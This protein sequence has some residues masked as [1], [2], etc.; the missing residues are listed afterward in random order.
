[1]ESTNVQLAHQHV[2]AIPVPS[3]TA[4][5]SR[6]DD[7]SPSSDSN[8]E[9]EPLY[10]DHEG[11]QSIIQPA[12]SRAATRLTSPAT[13]A[14][15]KKAALDYTSIS[16][17]DDDGIHA[18]REDHP[19]HTPEFQ[20]ST[21]HAQSQ[22]QSPIL[23][24]EH[25][26]Q[27]AIS[28]R[29]PSLKDFVSQDDT[30]SKSS[31][32]I[33]FGNGKTTRHR[34]SSSGG[35][36][37]F[38]RL[39][40]ALPSLPRP[41]FF[42]SQGS[43]RFSAAPLQSPSLA[44]SKTNSPVA[45]LTAPEPA[46][47]SVD[48]AFPLPTR[49][50]SHAVRP[51]APRRSTSDESMLYHSMS[52]VSSLGDDSRWHDVREM[53][54]N[55]FKAIT[56]SWDKPT[57]KLPNIP[58]MIPETLKRNSMLNWDSSQATLTE[59]PH[60]KDI[61]DLAGSPP[62]DIHLSELDRALESLTGDIVIMGGYRGSVLRSARTNRQVWVPVK[63]GLNMRKVN[64]EVG[65]DPEDE[66]QM[67]NTIYP[68][69]MLK[70]I[71]PV[72]ISKR[73]FKRLRSCDNAKS[74]KLRIWDYGYDW[75]L[76]PAILSRKLLQFLKNLPSNRPGVKPEAKGATI[77]AHSL[78]GLITRHAV[79]QNPDLFAGVIFAGTPQ[80]CINILGPLRNGDAVLLN[81]KVLTA[82]VNFS[83][84]T[85]FALLP[86]DGFCFVNK[87][88][89]EEYKVDFF[90]PS[91]WARYCWSPCV[92]TPLPVARGRTSTLGSLRDFSGRLPSPLRNRGY[93]TGNDS[94]PQQGTVRE[95][96]AD[97]GRKAEVTN[98]R[99][100]APQMGTLNDNSSTAR[101]QHQEAQAHASHD[102]EF[103]VR[104]MKYLTRTLAE[105]K[106][107]RSETAFIPEH[108]ARNAYPP[109]AVI[110][111]KEVPTVYAAHVTSREAI[112]RTDAYDNLLF[113]SGDGVVLAREAMLPPGY[114]LVKGGRISTDRGHITMLG[115]MDAVGRALQA[116]IR[117]RAKGIG[118]G[119]SPLAV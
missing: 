49:L 29:F 9:E 62:K 45:Q 63:V 95:S 34:R 65:L 83:L 52:R 119:K 43:P 57:F 93:S 97:A 32:S 87:T 27:Q 117:G 26:T 66:E 82:Q 41:S 51:K 36:E 68:D 22:D 10:I 21:L 114:D 89:G 113:Q 88:T 3:Y 105:V 55:R 13:P 11:A 100:L 78:G 30:G 4:Q 18:G 84:R 33:V 96:L 23:Q 48:A 15:E 54:N 80:R 111:G 73:L 61:P 90:D 108:A 110:Y 104:N 115:D 94:R 31:L 19:T 44:T 53:K 35:A 28:P 79:N 77:I 71:G 109:L 37:T 59:S 14:A 98:D 40:E 8:L 69:G 24:P 85:S 103:H 118:L 56:D 6:P 74:G 107:F 112:A 46:T 47:D 102:P 25:K 38:R 2:T 1:M 58:N 106:Q 81:E 101:H 86:D 67:E 72:D 7:A 75:R 99:T 60:G 20:P 5:E 50:S 42:S 39:R 91:D 64:L 16:F 116:I 70:N 17:G 92:G 76:S 12:I